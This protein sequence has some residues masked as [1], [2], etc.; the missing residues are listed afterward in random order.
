M[1]LTAQAEPFVPFLEEVKP[2]LPQHWEELALDRDKV[3]LDPIY[4][5]YL[6]MDAAGQMVAVTLRDRGKLVG[7]FVGV[8]KPHLHYRSCLTLHMDIFYLK[9]EVRGRMGGIRLFRAVEAEA[10]RRGV[11]RLYMGSKMHKDSSRLFEALG[12]TP[13]ET[14]F[15]KWVGA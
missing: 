11:K 2:L 7:Y 3:A 13:I 9:P 15:S 8:A 12:Y 6:R 10:K 1:S 14:Y 5:E 4:E